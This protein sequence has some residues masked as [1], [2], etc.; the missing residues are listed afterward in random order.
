MDVFDAVKARSS[1]RAY[2]PTPI[3][4]TVLGKILES[5]RLAPSAMNYQ[6]WHFIVV[7]DVEKRKAMSKAR[8]AGFLE[9]SPIVIVGCG[10][11]KKSPDWHVVDVTIALQN[12]VMTATEEGIGTCWI[13]SF[14]EGLIRRMLKIPNRWAIVALLSMGYPREKMDLSA[15]M[16][17]SK[18]RKKV[19]AI[20]S[21]EEFGA[22]E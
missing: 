17:R 15:L 20:V 19:S 3:P 13:G 1:V 7:T 5:A 16:A 22:S 14:D 6:P 8:W 11:L 9:E 21:H 12:M 4:E 18:S 2:A 10:D